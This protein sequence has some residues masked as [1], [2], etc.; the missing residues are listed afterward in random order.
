MKP[1]TISVSPE[2]RHYLTEYKRKAGLRS[3]DAAIEQ[4][5]R[6]GQHMV[7]RI[8]PAVEDDVLAVCRT[9]G[10]RRLVAFGSRVWGAPHANSDLDLA[11]EADEPFRLQELS[12][13]KDRLSRAF[14][15]DV[16]LVSLHGTPTRLRRR[17]QAEGVELLA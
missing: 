12:E 11:Y 3:I 14:G 6:S 7:E 2:N 8:W 5:F 4:L 15:L 1:T 13:F 17:I 9:F 16:D 10:V